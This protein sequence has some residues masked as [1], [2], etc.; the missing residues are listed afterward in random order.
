VLASFE[1]GHALARELD[2]ALDLQIACIQALGGFPVR[3]GVVDALV[4]VVIEST[5]DKLSGFQRYIVRHINLDA[6]A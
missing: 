1:L 6:L 5:L 3:Q 4:L 2:Q